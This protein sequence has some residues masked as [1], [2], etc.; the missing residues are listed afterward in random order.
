MDASLSEK[1]FVEHQTGAL[2]FEQSAFREPFTQTLLVLS[3]Q[4]EL[5]TLL[6][7]SSLR[8][9]VN[10]SVVNIHAYVHT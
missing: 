5:I 7:R 8:F 9:I 2:K 1:I 10:G 6:F 4:R 3:V